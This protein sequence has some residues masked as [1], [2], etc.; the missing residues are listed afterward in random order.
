MLSSNVFVFDIICN[1]VLLVFGLVGL[2]QHMSFLTKSIFLIVSK[3]GQQ[4]IEVSSIRCINYEIV[5]GY[6]SCT[7]NSDKIADLPT[8]NSLVSS[9]LYLV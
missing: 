3:R 4:E 9:M 1:L 7:A 6:S 8:F 5:I 2:I